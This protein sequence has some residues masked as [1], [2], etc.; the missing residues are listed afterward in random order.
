MNPAIHVRPIRRD[1][2]AK[3]LLLLL[4]FELLFA[5]EI[6]FVQIMCALNT[7]KQKFIVITTKTGM[8]KNTNIAL[9]LPNQQM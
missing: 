9:R 8:P 2:R 4:V 7:K 5:G 3:S 1:K 6:L